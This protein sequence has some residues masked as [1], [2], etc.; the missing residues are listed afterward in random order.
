MTSA[1]PALRID[2]ST[3]I[4]RTVRLM[5]TSLLLQLPR[6][7]L[8]LARR[9]HALVD[10]PDQELLDRSGAEAVDD[11]LHRRRRDAARRDAGA[12]TED[13][14]VEAMADVAATFEPA[15]QRPDARV[16]ERMLQLQRLA[17]LL[18]GRRLARPEEAQDG[19]LQIGQ[20]MRSVGLVTRCHVTICNTSR[21]AD[22][23]TASELH[24][25]QGVRRRALESLSDRERLTCDG[26]HTGPRQTGV[27]GLDLE[28]DR[29]VA[30]SL[31]SADYADPADV[32]CRAPRAAARGR[33]RHGS[34][35]A[36]GIE[37]LTGRGYREAAGL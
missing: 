14:A 9:Q 34:G 17:N 18:G 6:Q 24:V 1:M 28:D 37:G 10:H 25:A 20:P 8:D 21:T 11:V 33:Y 7:P 16:L 5:G 19:L 4:A 30:G 35:S 29:A 31:G 15:E 27:I 13:F 22:A 3:S 26:Q 36:G 12:I 23:R 2:V 32:A